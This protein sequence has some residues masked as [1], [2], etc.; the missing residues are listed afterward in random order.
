MLKWRVSD[1]VSS[2]NWI[3]GLFVSLTSP[4]VCLPNEPICPRPTALSTAPH[5]ILGGAEPSTEPLPPGDHSQAPPGT[6]CGQNVTARDEDRCPHGLDASEP[7][8]MTGGHRMLSST[9][10][11]VSQAEER[12]DPT[13]IGGCHGASPGPLPTPSI[14]LLRLNP[15]APQQAVAS[16]PARGTTWA[17]LCLLCLQDQLKRVKPSTQ[18]CW[19]EGEQSD[20]P[21]LREAFVVTGPCSRMACDAGWSGTVAVLRKHPARKPN[22]APGP[23]SVLGGKSTG[24]L[25]FRISV[26]R[27]IWREKNI[28]KLNSAFSY[29]SWDSQGKNTEV[30]C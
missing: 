30:V 20:S 14:S 15:L 16:E 17:P 5:G 8:F 21:L 12:P 22:W 29:C 28:A 3:P 24:S 18:G 25:R 6:L 10:I 23:S 19:R 9:G 27:P 26:N 1:S 2:V 11:V 4:Y 13:P 7:D